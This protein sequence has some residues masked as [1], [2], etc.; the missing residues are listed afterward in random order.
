MTPVSL[1][2]REAKLQKQGQ[3]PIDRVGGRSSSIYKPELWTSAG[4]WKAE[5]AFTAANFQSPPTL[6]TQLPTQ[7]KT[8]AGLGVYSFKVLDTLPPHLI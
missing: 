8:H 2:I 7:G 3:K 4:S 5:Q 1:G 6:C